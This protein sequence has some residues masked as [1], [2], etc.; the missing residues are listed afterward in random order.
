MDIVDPLIPPQPVDFATKPSLSF[1]LYSDEDGEVTT[2]VEGLE[3]PSRSFG[4]RSSSPTEAVWGGAG[5][6]WGG[7]DASSSTRGLCNKTFFTIPPLLRWRSYCRCGGSRRSKPGIGASSSSPR[8]AGG[9]RPQGGSVQCRWWCFGIE[10][11]HCQEAQAN[12]SPT[13]CR[14]DV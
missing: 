6:H 9:A 14:Y 13:C 5:P 7:V 1:H 8:E 2:D 10:S 3:R 12:Y 4:A 11:V